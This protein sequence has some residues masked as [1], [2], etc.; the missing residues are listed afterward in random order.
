M[1]QSSEATAHLLMALA[2]DE[3]L[4]RA[5]REDGALDGVFEETLRRFPLFGVA[6]R[7]TTDDMT[8]PTGSVP[9]R[10]GRCCASTIRS[11]TGS[12]GHI[13]FG[14][15]ANRPCP[16]WHLAPITVKA[17]TREL[18][19]RF[20]FATTAAHTRPLPNRGPCLMTPRGCPRPAAPR[21]AAVPAGTRPVGRTSGAASP[22]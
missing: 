6:H 16:A 1:V 4:Q 3:S 9:S 22:S 8:L 19:D 21:R 18:L 13:P 5:A 15:A 20:D 17:V 7:I 14:V 12:G 10:P 11:S 2:A